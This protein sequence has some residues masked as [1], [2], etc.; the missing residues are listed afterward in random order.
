MF[1]VD[2]VITYL[3]TDSLIDGGVHALRDVGVVGMHPQLAGARRRL[4]PHL[5]VEEAFGVAAS[6]TYTVVG[7]HHY[8]I[9]R[10]EGI[11]IAGLLQLSQ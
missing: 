10:K 6:G 5:H 8:P 2:D 7:H 9:S 3:V 4:P 1:Y 11:G